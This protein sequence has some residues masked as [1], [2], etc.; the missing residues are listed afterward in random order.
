[1]EEFK[2]IIAKLDQGSSEII[3]DPCREL[4]DFESKFIF[5]YNNKSG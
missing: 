5:V 2:K 3:W 4:F 1:M